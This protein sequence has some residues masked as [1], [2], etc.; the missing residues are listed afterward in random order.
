[1]MYQFRLDEYKVHRS[2]FHRLR[3]QLAWSLTAS[4][5]IPL[6]IYVLLRGESVLNATGTHFS[7][8][9]ALIASCVTLLVLRQ[10]GGIF[11]LEQSKWVL[12]V[13]LTAWGTLSAT[14]LSFRLPYSA[15]FLLISLPIT[16]ISFY[17]LT[18]LMVRHR[19]A[20]C[21]VIPIGRATD[22]DFAS[23]LQIR[24]LERP[25]FPAEAK[26]V[27]V[28]DLHADL[29][30]EWERFLTEAS[31]QGYPIFHVTQLREAMT[32][33]VQFDHLSENSFGAMIPALTYKKV[34]TVIDIVSALCLLPILLPVML[35]IAFAI[36]L[37]SPGP[38]FFTQRRM[39]Y[40]GKIFR[41]IKFRTMTVTEDGS[42]GSASM[43]DANDQRITRIGRLLRPMRIDE[44]PQVFNILAG[45]MSWIGPR[46]E[47][48]SLS[49]QYENE[50]PNYRYRHLVR[51]GISGWAQVHQGHVTTVDDVHDKLR[52]D[53]YYVKNI[54]LWLDIVIALRTLRV[55]LTGFGAK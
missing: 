35:V 27:I 52:Y 47:A 49:A 9:V 54:S 48:V 13:L 19:R 44:L 17:V 1:M 50:I 43:T 7:I 24:I 45:E 18:A 46:P 39:G 15:T 2:I 23:R 33:K 20:I 10:V 38:A 55:I 51:P 21:Y 28:A 5:V 6:A 30:E 8:A 40:R 4:V 53:F 31:L 25:R 22:T 14:L 37:D 32:G 16:I 29:G 34:K 36:K 42:D 11:R 12:P 3:T 41:M 26:A